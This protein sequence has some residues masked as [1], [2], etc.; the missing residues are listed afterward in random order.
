MDTHR[1]DVSGM[2][3][4]DAVVRLHKTITPLSPG[5]LVRILADDWAVLIDLKHYARRGGHAWVS[6]AQAGDGTYE[7]EVKRGA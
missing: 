7:A 2:T 6:E 3:C 1:I 5:E 4:S